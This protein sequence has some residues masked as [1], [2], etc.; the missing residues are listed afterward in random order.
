[1]PCADLILSNDTYVGSLNIVIKLQRV[2]GRPVAKLSDDE[3]KTMCIDENY[4]EY[5]KRAV[6]Y[7]IEEEKKLNSK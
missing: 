7:R 6:N 5:L 2:N 4:F 1:M 3:G